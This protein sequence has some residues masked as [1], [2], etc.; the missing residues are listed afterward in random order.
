MSTPLKKKFLT[1]DERGTRGESISRENAIGEAQKQVTIKILNS[2]ATTAV[3]EKF[4]L[5]LQNTQTIEVR[6]LSREEAE[7]IGVGVLVPRPKKTPYGSCL[8][9]FRISNPGHRQGEDGHRQGEEAVVGA[10]Q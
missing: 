10:R 5:V 9:K 2:C 7:R 6:H 1:E 8:R 4:A 3:T